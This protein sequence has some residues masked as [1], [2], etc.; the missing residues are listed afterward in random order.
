MKIRM[1]QLLRCCTHQ[2]GDWDVPAANIAHTGGE[3][4]MFWESSVLHVCQSAGS[5]DVFLS[6]YHQYRAH[7]FG[8][9]TVQQN[10]LCLH[11][12]LHHLL[13]I[14]LLVHCGTVPQS[15]QYCLRWEDDWLI[16]TVV[17]SVLWSCAQR[18][19]TF[20]SQERSFIV[21]RGHVSLSVVLWLSEHV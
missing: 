16:Q 19:E 12:Q 7:Q 3:I 11:L 17:H 6:S 21:E 2:Y 8:Q 1:R 5:Q 13:G 15:S 4:R 10:L 18:K 20:S 14:C 9:R